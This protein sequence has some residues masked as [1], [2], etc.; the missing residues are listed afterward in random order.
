MYNFSG[1]KEKPSVN[2]GTK[3]LP[4]ECRLFTKKIKSKQNVF[5]SVS[6][7]TESKNTNTAKISTTDSLDNSGDTSYSLSSRSNNSAED[8][9]SENVSEDY[10]TESRTHRAKPINNKAIHNE[11]DDTYTNSCNFNF[12]KINISK[13]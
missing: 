3:Y 10:D 6:K 2:F 1:E 5:E 12:K 11:S 4:V 13:D 8:N 9:L 7:N